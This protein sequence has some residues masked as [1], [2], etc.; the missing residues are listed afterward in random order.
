[1]CTHKF[2]CRR[3]RALLCQRLGLECGSAFKSNCC[4]HK[5]RVCASEEKWLKSAHIC[6]FISP[7]HSAVAI[8]NFYGAA[9]S[10][11]R[12]NTREHQQPQG[13]S[14]SRG[15]RLLC[16][17]AFDCAPPASQAKLHK[18][19]PDQRARVD[20]QPIFHA[21]WRRKPIMMNFLSVGILCFIFD[22]RQVANSYFQQ[23]HI[24]SIAARLT[25]DRNLQA[26]AALIFASK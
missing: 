24:F 8:D 16:G 11:F 2:Y 21:R 3:I 20:L 23:T 10:Y 6:I 26:E 5:T 4:S 18:G 14:I 15:D 9:R 22:W 1:M 25:R 13:G 7:A 17:G 12:T 19:D